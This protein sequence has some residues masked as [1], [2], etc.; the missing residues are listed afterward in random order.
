MKAQSLMASATL[1]T[2]RAPA[3]TSSAPAANALASACGN[4]RGRTST[5]SDSA[6]F[7]MARATEPML[8]GWLGSIRTMRTRFVT[9]D[10][11]PPP[12]ATPAQYRHARRAARRRFNRQKLIQARFVESR[13]QGPQ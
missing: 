13:Q 6:I 9:G 11:L 1:D 8:P 5:R 2:M 10:I 3:K 12:Y 4:E 7:F